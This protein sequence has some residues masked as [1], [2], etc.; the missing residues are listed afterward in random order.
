MTSMRGREVSRDS[1]HVIS[2]LAEISKN[3]NEIDP[4]PIALHGV[5]PSRE[6]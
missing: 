3:R 2:K 5:G 4:W 6:N 1:P